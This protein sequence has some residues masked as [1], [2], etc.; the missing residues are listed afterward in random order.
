MKKWEALGGEEKASSWCIHSQPANQRPAAAAASSSAAAGSEAAQHK[1]Q[2]VEEKKKKKKHVD[3]FFLFFFLIPYLSHTHYYTIRNSFLLF[4]III[5]IFFLIILLGILLCNHSNWDHGTRPIP[6]PT[7]FL[8][9]IFPQGVLSVCVSLP[10]SSS[11]Q[12]TF[13]AHTETINSSAVDISWTRLLW[14][15]P[16]LLYAL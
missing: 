9:T 8:L 5:F 16:C 1:A 11:R 4:F 3:S 10:S 15:M 13:P 14:L 7:T 2:A 6:M 12:W